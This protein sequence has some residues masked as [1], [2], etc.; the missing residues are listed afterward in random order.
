MKKECQLLPSTTNHRRREKMRRTKD[1]DPKE[2]W[3][4]LVAI[5]IVSFFIGLLTRI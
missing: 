2:V 1:R 4:T 5:V 3:M